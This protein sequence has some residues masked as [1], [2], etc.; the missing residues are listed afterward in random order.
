MS[1]NPVEFPL[2]E[3]RHRVQKNCHISDARYA[4]DY[5]LCIYLLKMRE[6]YRWEAGLP[7]TA[8]LDN[9]RIGTW[10]R[11]RETLWEDLE[12]TDFEPLP[13]ADQPYDPFATADINRQL[14]PQGLVYSGGIG[15]QGKPHFFLGRLHQHRSLNGYNIFVSGEE[16][17]R[18]LTAPPAMAL[19]EDIFV[20]R[21]SLKRMLWEKIEEWRWNQPANAMA[22]AM[23]CYD[24]ETDVD[25]ALEAMTEAELDSVLLHEIGEVQAGERLG[26]VWEEMLLAL[27]RTK[28]EI[29]LRALRDH[30]ADALSTLPALLEQENEATLHF[31]FANLSSMRKHLFPSLLDAYQQWCE[32][33]ERSALQ[34]RVSTG[35]RHW[36]ALAKE[37]VE[38]FRHQGSE[39]Q[40]AIQDLLEQQ[41]L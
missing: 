1:V 26:P 33:G 10:L 14:A 41:R 38:L 34:D 8:R 29:M 20:R 37:A 13:V 32:T 3:L 5:T 19:G 25:A 15:R 21:E 28:A 40:A 17:A 31:Y 4:A 36:P 23:A 9:A 39:A 30:L 12:T 27:S 2:T 24:F 22:R 11:E 35:R 6:F 16:F 18:D 7:Y